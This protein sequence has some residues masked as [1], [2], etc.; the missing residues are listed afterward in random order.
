MP[1]PSRAGTG[2]HPH[3]APEEWRDDGKCIWKSCTVWRSADDFEASSA[4]P[5][6]RGPRITE[7]AYLRAG[8][9]PTH[10]VRLDDTG[11]CP[12][13]ADHDPPKP[14]DLL[15]EE[16]VQQVAEA[17][18][19]APRLALSEELARVA[20]DAVARWLMASHEDGRPFGDVHGWASRYASYLLRQGQPHEPT[21]SHIVT[22]P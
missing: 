4:Y 18:D 12:H 9:C 15:T 16:V 20:V 21:D 22:M 13:A 6:G 8:L 14:T 17:I 19:A 5:A 7:P 2:P 10:R 1:E 11:R 3:H